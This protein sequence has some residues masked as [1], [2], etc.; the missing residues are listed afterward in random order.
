MRTTLLSLLF[1]SLSTFSFAQITGRVVA[2]DG[3]TPIAKCNVYL[4]GYTIGTTTDQFG[5]FSL[6]SVPNG[7]YE[8]VFSHVTFQKHIEVIELN[9]S[10][11]QL[12]VKLAENIRELD[13]FILRGDK[14]LGKRRRD[15]KRFKEF[16]FG[17]E[18]NE[19]LIKIINEDLIDFKNEQG[20]LTTADDYSLHLINEHLGYDIQYYLKDFMYSEKTKVALGFPKF[21]N[22]KPDNPATEILWAE[23]RQR[24]Y[25]GSIRHF[26]NALLNKSLEEEGFETYLTNT[27]PEVTGEADAYY[28]RALGEGSPLDDDKLPLNFTIENTQIETIKKIN[29]GAVLDIGFNREFAKNGGF[30]RSQIKLTEPYVYVYTNGAVL[31]PNALKLFGQIAD[32][33]AFNMLPYDFVSN[34]TLILSENKERTQ[35]L[36]Q[37]TELG[38]SKLTEKLYVHTNRNDFYQ[39]ETI[40]FKTYAVAG[41]NHQPSPLSIKTFVE[42]IKDDSVYHALILETN[43]GMSHGSLQ[44][45]STAPQGKYML[46]AYTNWMKNEP[47]D[48]FFYKPIYVEEGIS[49]KLA[50]KDSS[51]VKTKIDLQ[52]FPESGA[53][54]NGTTQKVAF[55]ATNQNGLPE[56]VQGHIYNDQNELVTRFASTHD[57]MGF[58][59]LTPDDGSDYFALTDETNSMFKLPEERSEFYMTVDNL[60]DSSNVKIGFRTTNL[61]QHGEL[62]LLAQSR[63]WLNYTIQIELEEESKKIEIPKSILSDGIIHLT[64]FDKKGRPLA[65]RLIYNEK[66]KN[67]NIQISTNPIQETKNKASVRLKVTDTSG[68]PVVGYFSLSALNTESLRT[69]LPQRNIVSHLLLTS[70]LKGYIHQPNYYFNTANK[71]RLKHLD[72][73]MLTHGWTRFKWENLE[74][75][76]AQEYQFPYDEGID[77]AGQLF[78]RGRKKPVK[79]G[80]VTYIS[81]REDQPQ[82][83]FVNTNRRGHFYLEQINPK[84]QKPVML[85]GMTKK[86]SNEVAFKVDTS[87][88]SAS[89]NWQLSTP[90][91][92]SLTNINDWASNI[93]YQ[94]NAELERLNTTLNTLDAPTSVAR[95]RESIYGQPSASY[96][97]D[98]FIGENRQGN[99]FQYMNGRIPGL[100][101]TPQGPIIRGT[102]A[103]PFGGLNL[104][105]SMDSLNTEGSAAEEEV[106][107]PLIFVD[108]VKT[109]YGAAS[110]IEVNSVERVEIF[111]G[112]DAVVFGMGATSG[113]ILIFTRLDMEEDYTFNGV[114]NLRVKGFHIAKEFYQPQYEVDSL[115]FAR[116]N[117]KTV[118]W[119]PRIVTD[120]YGEAKVEFY[121]TESLAD[122]LIQVE[123]IS[124]TGLPGAATLTYSM[125][126]IINEP[127]KN[128]TS[129][130]GAIPNQANSSHFRH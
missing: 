65:E 114:Y 50:A 74:N 54:V 121:N 10:K 42:L 55:K 98:E 117:R 5:Y 106:G 87:Y 110:S 66:E 21:T 88:Q 12:L 39:G 60:T 93:G 120:E 97:F 130:K 116:D 86:G 18:Y 129:E 128:T 33:G 80:F 79:D 63:G 25:N 92:A 84:G 59:Y 8:L 45:P 72:L 51:V 53:L 82:T 20:I 96:K 35:I 43:E 36:N 124:S 29:F 64:A 4:A 40:W 122:V 34:D 95:V 107:K 11:A 23:N 118:F 73:V 109:T 91:L 46:R 125:T 104:S 32:E 108:N 123:G 78:I 112:P 99:V 71:T 41:P 44:I 113:V 14:A 47:E 75:K 19:A 119:E 38:K 30:Q 67:L 17:K 83:E 77:V 61:R 28:K 3:E 70:D 27:D 111:K 94:T 57:G 16:F 13:S 76:I 49:Q 37:I 90:Y 7:V 6:E 81:N 31:N 105:E 62:F 100:Q 56:E 69:P 1:I 2:A 89:L 127:N 58:F 24:A 85:K 101:I 52:F 102:Q 26:F 115:T 15:L 103:N 9:G 126:N 48:Y 68:N 22:L